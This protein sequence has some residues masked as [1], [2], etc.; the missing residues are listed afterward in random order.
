VTRGDADLIRHTEGS[1]ISGI[2]RRGGCPR[3]G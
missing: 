1:S 2:G 3:R